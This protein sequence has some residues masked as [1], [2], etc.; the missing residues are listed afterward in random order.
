MTVRAVATGRILFASEF[1]SLR[2]ITHEPLTQ[3]RG[4]L[5]EHVPR[6]PLEPI[7]FQ[8]HWSKVKVTWVIGCF[9]SVCLMLRLPADST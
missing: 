6:Q 5:H 3:L 2:K 7:E 8:G 4:I 1:F 9:F